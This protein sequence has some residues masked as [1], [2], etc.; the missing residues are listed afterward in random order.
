MKSDNK[1]HVKKESFCSKLFL[2][3]FPSK[4]CFFVFLISF[5][6]FFSFFIL[7]FFLFIRNLFVNTYNLPFDKKQL[8]IHNY[9]YI[10]SKSSNG[11]VI[12]GNRKVEIALL[13]NDNLF[14][15]LVRNGFDGNNVNEIISSILK[16]VNLKDLREGQKFF[17]EYTFKSIYKETNVGKNKD[18]FPKKAD[19]VEIRNIDKMV[20]KMPKGIKYIIEKN[21]NEYICHIEKPKL[22]IKT[23]IISGTIQSS[24]FADVLVSDINATTLFNVL[25]E[26]AFLI[27]FQ[28][29]I[30]PKDKFIFV[31]ETTRD[32]DGD[33]VNEKVLYSNLILS[34]K[35]YEIFNFH[36][37]FYD[38]NGKSIQKN[39]LKTP[40]DGA[41]I[42]SGFTTRRK[43]PILGYT[44]AHKGIDLAVPT[45]TPIYSAG[46]GVVSDLQLNHSDYGKVITIKHNREY[47]T[48]YA[49]MSRVAHLKVGQRVKQRQII[50]YVGMTGLATGPHLHYEVMRYGKHI[51]PKN[52]KAV[53][54]KKLSKDKLEELNVIIND[55]DAMLAE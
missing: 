54:T 28:R 42:S 35:K 40:V 41:R 50:G 55:I 19:L 3:F 38:R 30:H 22:V 43:H 17:L 1:F 4:N 29:D 7:I 48:R 15:A 5:L 36:G 24:V 44:R 53:E 18:N 46:D 31:L 6:S 16:K 13:Q 12:N 11:F 20:F 14:S 27:D 47:S 39:L 33:F 26:Y 10:K 2:F 21:Q 37:K 25:N 49:H 8:F 45:G 51:N 52:V 23:H 34:N 9:N 32:D